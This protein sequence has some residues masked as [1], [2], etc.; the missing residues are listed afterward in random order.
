MEAWIEDRCEE[1]RDLSVV[2][3]IVSMYGQPLLETTP[4]W[5]L[6]TN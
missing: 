3:L 1:L 5:C 6:L 4:R 2:N